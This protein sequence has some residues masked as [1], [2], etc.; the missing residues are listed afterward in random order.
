[1]GKFRKNDVVQFIENHKWCACLGIITEVKDCDGDIRYMIGV[2]IPE[3]GT[4][5]I[6]SMESKEE[7]EYIGPTVFGVADDGEDG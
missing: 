1:M 2:P 7:F 6:F 4:A 5:F 3:K